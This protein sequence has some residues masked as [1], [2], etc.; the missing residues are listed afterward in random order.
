MKAQ[1]R[2]FYFQNI[3]KPQIGHF[4]AAGVKPARVR[5]LRAEVSGAKVGD[6]ITVATFEEEVKTIAENLAQMPTK[7]IGL[8]KRLLNQSSN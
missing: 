4:K 6:V 1:T 2:P 7:A 3:K 8:T 5:E